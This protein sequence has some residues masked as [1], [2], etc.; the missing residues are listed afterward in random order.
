MTSSRSARASQSQEDSPELDD[1]LALLVELV[2]DLADDLLDDVLEADDAGDAAVLVDDDG[3]VHAPAPE[4]LEQGVDP[5]GLGHEKRLAHQ[6]GEG[7]IPALHQGAQEVLRVEDAHDRIDAVAVDGDAGMAAGH[8][9]LEELLA[10]RIDGK[11]H[12]I[13]ARDHDFLDGRLAELLH[14]LD[15]LPLVGV[16]L[17]RPRTVS[18]ALGPSQASGS[19]ASG[20]RAF[21]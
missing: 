16:A 14:A 20:G 11:E 9:L 19:P 6:V 2:L 18:V 1:V 4:L 12:G 5:L 8:D 17:R 3:D 7:E 21:R 15:H 10:A 13:D